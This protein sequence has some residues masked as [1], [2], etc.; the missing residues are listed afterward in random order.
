VIDHATDIRMRAEIRAGE[1]LAEM[2]ERGERTGQ[3]QGKGKGRKPQPLQKLSDIGV[4]KS[5]S[6]RWQKLAA[7]PKEDQEQKIEQARRSLIEHAS[8]MGWKLTR[9]GSSHALP[10][11]ICWE[12]TLQKVPVFIGVFEWNRGCHHQPE[13][14]HPKSSAIHK[15]AGRLPHLYPPKAAELVEHVRFPCR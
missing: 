5:Q 9:P 6:S 11:A 3:G 15:L 8:G 13:A 14:Q 1:L 12:D 4:S 7:L 2:A 10:S